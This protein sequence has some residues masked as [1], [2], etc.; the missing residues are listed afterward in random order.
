MYNFKKLKKQFKNIKSNQ[1]KKNISPPRSTFSS[2]MKIQKYIIDT[3]L[4]K[5]KTLTP[6]LIIF[7]IGIQP[8]ELLLSSLLFSNKVFSFL[9]KLRD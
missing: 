3:P 4:I 9:F 6:N 1:E 5:K 8:I 2:N 7:V